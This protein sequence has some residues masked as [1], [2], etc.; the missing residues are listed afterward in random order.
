MRGYGTYCE[1]GVLRTVYTYIYNTV[2]RYLQHTRG[3]SF[4]LVAKERVEKTLMGCD[5]VGYWQ[6]KV[7]PNS[8]SA[9]TAGLFF[10]LILLYGC[11]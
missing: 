7:I 5:V 3:I 4:G 8:A 11:I 6:K 2:E 9:R 10:E 1:L